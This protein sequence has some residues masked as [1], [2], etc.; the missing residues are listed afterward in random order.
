V[1]TYSAPAYDSGS[2]VMSAQDRLNRLGY[3]AGPADGVMGPQTRDAIADFQNDNN[4]P[5][6]GGLDTATIRALGL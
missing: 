5:A 2:L 3:S 6:S 1:T 4:L